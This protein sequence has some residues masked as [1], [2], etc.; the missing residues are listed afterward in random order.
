MKSCYIKDVG[1]TFWKSVSRFISIFFM[2]ML[3]AGV[4][5]GLQAVSPNMK[6]SVSDY[7]LKNNFMD[8]RV[9]SAGGF[10]QADADA[11]A[12]LDCVDAVMPS[13]ST[14]AISAVDGKDYVIKLH[15][16]P[17]GAGADNNGYI[18]RV[19]LLEG[20]LPENDNECV[21]VFRSAADRIRIGDTV[22]IKEPR[23]GLALFGAAAFEI[24]GV[25]KTPYYMSYILGGSAIGSGQLD[26]VIYVRG[27]VFPAPVYTEL[28]IGV[29]G[30]GTVNQFGKGYDDKITAAAA[31]IK[32]KFPGCIVLDRNANES[33]AG[34]ADAAGNMKSIATVFPMIFFLVAALVSLTT[35]TRMIDEERLTIGTYRALGYGNFKIA[36]KYIFYALTATVIG[37]AAG[38]AAGFALFSYIL[39]GAYGIVFNF[40]RLSIGFYPGITMLTAAL[41]LAFTLFA[42]VYSCVKT[43]REYPSRLMQHKA[44]KAGRRVL[45]ERVKPVWKRLPFSYK[46]TARNI[47]LSPKRFFMTVTGI[48]GCM[49]LILI[50]FGIRDSVNAI[51]T[52]Q[53]DRVF[54]YDAAAGISG[55]VTEDLKNA[56]DDKTLISDYGLTLKKSLNVV[57]ERGE[58]YDAL[59]V[60]PQNDDK[61]KDFITIQNRKDKK[62]VVFDAG[63]VVVTEK[64][65]RELGL[66]SGSVI[67]VNFLDNAGTT[68]NLAVTGITENYLLEYVYV[69]G[70]VYSDVFGAQP[71]FNQ[72]LIKAAD[73]NDAVRQNLSDR[74]FT[75][76]GVMAVSFTADTVKTFENSF[77]SLDSITVVLIVSAA[78][79]AVVVL[80]NLTNINIIER[81]REIATLKVLGFFERETNM[82]INRETFTLTI[83]GMIAGV[84]I[85]LAL[86]GFVM[87]TVEMKIMLI[88]RVIK[89]LS[90]VYSFGLT[91]VFSIIV[92][93]LIGRKINKID[94]IESLKSVD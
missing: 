49:A 64:L 85:G 94:M 91:S 54:K 48:A 29:K 61:L 47:F 57:N 34:F 77:K 38:I 21:I 28:F 81:K 69:G 88:A 23:I 1:R 3:G 55:A 31:E 86:F 40:P 53:F 22:S 5:A 89:P 90:Y 70:G 72:I 84:F 51:L 10:S 76:G 27:S 25:V 45:L 17:G 19:E 80:Y 37:S 6:N 74:L 13:V 78:L 16:L 60:V 82:Y 93:L 67:E 35:M 65:A 62:P 41:T 71:E 92:S 44:P 33:H 83:L 42:T 20:R 12:A 2:A 66:K 50:G 9:V 87:A 56:L 24:T 8:L 75:A 63:S 14:E 30:A 43:L 68:Y 4:F 26:Y 52:N 18:N 32:A 46:I 59:L 73:G 79:L 7:Y 58:A 36:L 11:A 15:T 39:W